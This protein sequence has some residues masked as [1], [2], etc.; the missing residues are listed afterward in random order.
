MVACGGNLQVIGRHAA[1]PSNLLGMADIPPACPP[2]V[3]H[4]EFHGSTPATLLLCSGDQA[5]AAGSETRLRLVDWAPL[6][7]GA[8]A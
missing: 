8:S 6:S 1:E 7:K 4:R 3:V 2:H 5:L